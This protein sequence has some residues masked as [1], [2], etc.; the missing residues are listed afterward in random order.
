MRD[1]ADQPSQS[2][3]HS[4]KT[5]TDLGSLF[6]FRTNLARTQGIP[7]RRPGYG[8]HR[9]DVDQRYIALDFSVE[10]ESLRVA[11]LPIAEAIQSGLNMAPRATTC[12]SL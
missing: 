12:F 4:P 9:F 6:T 11:A 5:I 1:G 10:D 3:L 7:L 8:T 2:N